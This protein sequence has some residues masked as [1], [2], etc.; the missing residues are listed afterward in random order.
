MKWFMVFLLGAFTFFQL[1]AQDASTAQGPLISWELPSH[2]FGDITQGDKVNHTFRF[3]NTGNQPLVLTNVEVT[4]GCTTPKG[5]PRDPIPPGGK[6]ELTVA[7]NSAGKFG[8]QNKVITIT[9]NSV[10]S[11]NQVM[12]TANVLE[13]KDA[14]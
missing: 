7:F 5:W 1:N 10:G 9:S 2:D 4:C 12:I 13:K 8:K 11:T 6:G 14:N 3:T